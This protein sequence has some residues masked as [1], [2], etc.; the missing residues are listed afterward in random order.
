MRCPPGQRRLLA[1]PGCD[2]GSTPDP[3]PSKPRAAAAQAVYFQDVTTA[4]GLPSRR[5]VLARRHLHH[6]RDHPRRRRP[7]RL[8]QRRPPRHPPNLPRE[9]GS[10][11]A[12]RRPTASS[13]SSPTA[14]SQRSRAPPASAAPASTTASPSATSTTTAS[15]TSTSPTT[16]P[17]SSSATTARAPSPTPPRRPAFARPQ[18]DPPEWSSDRRV[19]RLRPRRGPGPVRLHFARFDPSLVCKGDAG[20]PRDYCGPHTVPG[21]PRPALPQQR[22]RHLHR[23]DQGRRRRQAQPRVGR[24]LRRPHRRRLARR[25]RRQRRGAQPEPLGQPAAT[26]RSATRPPSASVA[27]SAAGQPEANMGVAVGDVANDGRLARSSSPTSPARRTRCTWTRRRPAS[28][29][30]RRPLRRPR[31]WRRSTAR[32][33][34]G[35]RLL[36]LR[37]RRRPR[38]RRRQR[39]RRQASPPRPAASSSAPFWNHFAEPNLL[40]LG[41]GTGKFADA[42]LRAGDFTRRV[43]SHA[44]PRLRRP[45]QRRRAWTW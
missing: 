23:R 22:R 17:T 42:E 6:A 9:A 11:S 14:R 7:V 1:L 19:L 40:F 2:G 33:P 44:R 15:S 10:A 31:A 25:L 34:A 37:Q 45:R 26:A 18:T 32:T 4:K 5:V 12:T 3:K 21:V 41:D 20:R 28:R 36:R 13:A 24:R 43:E 8:R 27:L 38:P 39:P 29:L 35:V 30:L 16:A